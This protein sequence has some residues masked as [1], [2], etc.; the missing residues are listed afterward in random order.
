MRIIFYSLFA[1]SLFFVG[2]DSA[3]ENVSAKSVHNPNTAESPKEMGNLPYMEFERGT[4]YDFGHA[5]TGEIL[6][7]TFYFK[8]T[9]KSDLIIS[10]VSTSCGCTVSDYTDRPIRSGEEGTVSLTFDTKGRN[11]HQIKRATVLTNCQP[12]RIVLTVTADLEKLEK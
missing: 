3:N 5:Q 4:K 9:G 11:G 2:C 8:N 10:D 1:L 12:N 7:N 6:V